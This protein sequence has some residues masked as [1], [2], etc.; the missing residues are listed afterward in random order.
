MSFPFAPEQASTYAW[1]VDNLFFL[2]TGLTIFFT[3][4]VLF[5]LL[6]LAIR[7]RRGA[8]VNRKNAVDHDLRLELAWSLGP[9]FLG[10]GVYIM[11][12]KPFTY[13]YRPPTDAME[14]FVIGKRWMWHMPH[15][16]GIRENNELHVPV[17]RAIKL[18]MISQDVIHGFSVPAF[19]MK[20]DVLP[21]RYNTCWFQA[22]KP[23]KY[24]LFCTE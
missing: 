24:H 9:M 7:Y 1:D 19:R 16:N 22:T 11:A 5:L 15:D 14:I 6:F 2:L 13:V 8:K 3:A 17:G 10:L 23:G 18:T 21:G 4:L 12:T 20:R